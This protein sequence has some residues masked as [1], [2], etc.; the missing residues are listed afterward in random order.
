[1]H[2]AAT[3]TVDNTKSWNWLSHVRRTQQRLTRRD[4]GFED[5]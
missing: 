2:L 4:L 1:M 5:T 3:L